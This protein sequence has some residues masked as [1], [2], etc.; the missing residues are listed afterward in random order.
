MELKWI[1]INLTGLMM[2]NWDNDIKN[3]VLQNFI[4]IIDIEIY[5]FCYRLVK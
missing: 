1:I 3:F 4:N 2:N 5:N